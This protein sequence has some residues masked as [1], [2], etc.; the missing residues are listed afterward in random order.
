MIICIKNENN[1]ELIIILID[2]LTDVL[3]ELLTLVLNK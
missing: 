1:T 3:N 2:Q